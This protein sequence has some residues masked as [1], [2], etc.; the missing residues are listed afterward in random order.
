M[1]GKI[2]EADATKSWLR[3][4]E[5]CSHKEVTIVVSNAYIHIKLVCFPLCSD[6]L[7]RHIF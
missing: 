3:L 7:L 6:I 1:G 2:K 4:N 5:V